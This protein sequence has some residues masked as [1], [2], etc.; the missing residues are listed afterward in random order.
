M[1]YLFGRRLRY[2]LALLHF[3]IVFIRGN[4]LNHSGLDVCYTAIALCNVTDKVYIKTHIVLITSI[5]H[6][7]SACM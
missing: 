4:V 6:I 2:D 7:L 5:L 3:L 1:L